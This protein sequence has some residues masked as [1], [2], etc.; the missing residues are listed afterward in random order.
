MTEAQ[1]LAREANS[2][3]EA[4]DAQGRELTILERR[5]VQDCLDGVKRIQANEQLSRLNGGMPDV[6]MSNGRASYGG[7]DPGSAFIASEGYKAIK[8]SGCSRADVDVRP[9]RRRAAGEGHAARGRRA[10]RL[11][12]RRRSGSARRRSSRASS[13]SCFSR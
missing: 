9:G 11:R 10:R 12:H 5:R 13:R 7:G 6:M 1:R 4:A 3:F 2:Y 8:N